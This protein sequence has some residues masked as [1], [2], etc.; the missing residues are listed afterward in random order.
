MRR[1]RKKKRKK[2]RKR[3]RRRR[4]AKNNACGWRCWALRKQECGKESKQQKKGNV[5]AIQSWR[6]SCSHNRGSQNPSLR[7]GGQVTLVHFAPA[8]S[9]LQLGNFLLHRLT[10]KLSGICQEFLEVVDRSV[11]WQFELFL[12]GRGD[13]ATS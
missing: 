1:R 13:R 6:M 10:G 7:C 11:C 9:C 8:W 12:G 5:S 2:R 4:E 3:R